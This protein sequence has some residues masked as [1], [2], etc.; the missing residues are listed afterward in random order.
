MSAIAQVVDG[1][2]QQP[3]PT[4]EKDKPKNGNS[5]DKDAF[6]KLLVAQMKYQ[7]PLEPTANTE[8]VSQLATFSQLEE[9]QNMTSGMTLMRASGLVGEYVSMTTMTSGGSTKTISGYVDSVVYEGGK[10]YLSIDGAKYSIDDLDQVI[11]RSYIAA[12]D[13]V[14]G[15]IKRLEELPKI[16]EMTKDEAQEVARLKLE[17][18]A[19]TPYEQAFVGADAKKLYAEYVS[20]MEELLGDEADEGTK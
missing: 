11:D 19:M 9:M 17:Y 14:S 16:D 4:K 6:L 18:E 7:D 10:A 2:I 20:A 8:F 3:K 1:V 15:W 5:L 13:K 12:F